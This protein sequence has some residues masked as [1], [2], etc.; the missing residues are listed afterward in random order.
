MLCRPA[1]SNDGKLVNPVLG[2]V[3]QPLVMQISHTQA[4]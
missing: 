4:K 2:H 3:L 1:C